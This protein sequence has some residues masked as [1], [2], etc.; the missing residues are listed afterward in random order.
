M[1]YKFGDWVITVDN[2]IG[3]V[4][5]HIYADEYFVIFEKGGMVY[6]ESELKEWHGAW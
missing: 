2:K 4:R 6:K 3:M 5:Q 1:K